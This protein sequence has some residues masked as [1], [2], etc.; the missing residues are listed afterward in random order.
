[1]SKK[2]LLGLLL[3]KAA[4]CTFFESLKYAELKGNQEYISK[5]YNY[6]G[7]IFY[8]NHKYDDAIKYFKTAIESRWN[9]EQSFRSIPFYLC[10]LSYYELRQYDTAMNYFA[11][12]LE[13]VNRTG[14]R[15]R[16]HE[17]ENDRVIER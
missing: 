8:T 12:A 1:M 17:I 6:L 14:N 5:S 3:T 13:L 10:G 9:G 11:A 16:E 15:E 4:T 7:I 2:P